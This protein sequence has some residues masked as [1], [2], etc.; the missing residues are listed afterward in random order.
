MTPDPHTTEIAEVLA[1]AQ[2]GHATK[3]HHRESRDSG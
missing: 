2:R 1:R 3:A